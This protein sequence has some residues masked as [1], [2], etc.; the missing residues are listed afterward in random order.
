MKRRP[1]HGR[2]VTLA[3]RGR[4]PARAAL[5][6]MSAAM[7]A[8]IGQSGGC[9]ADRQYTQT[10]LNTLQSRDFDASYETAYTA[11]INA[12]FDGGYII[13]SSD[14]DAGFIAASR[15]QGNG[16]SGFQFQGVQVKVGAA[17]RRTSVRISNTDGMGQQQVNKEVIDELFNLIERRLV[18]DLTGSATTPP[19]QAQPK[20]SGR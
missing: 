8:A 6:C 13:R 3:G 12:L 9:A 7:M 16:W 20:D 11:T 1:P 17:G 19:G 5:A 4:S 18:G 15:T 2:A 10:E 14:K